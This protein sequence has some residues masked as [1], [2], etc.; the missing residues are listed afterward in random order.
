MEDYKLRMKEEFDELL[1][2]AERLRD[3]LKMNEE[4][5]L[6]FELTCPVELL[7]KQLRIMDD[8]LDVLRERADIEKVDLTADLT[9]MEKGGTLA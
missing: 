5:T 6:D 8:Y 4:G 3:M 9:Y 1:G 7:R 2:R